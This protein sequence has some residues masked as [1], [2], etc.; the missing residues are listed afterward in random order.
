MPWHCCKHQEVHSACKNSDEVLVQWGKRLNMVLPLPSRDLPFWYRLT[1]SQSSHARTHTHTRLMALCLSLPGTRKVKPIWILLKQ[2][3]VSCSGISWAIWKSAPRSRQITTS[4]PHYSSFFY[5][6]DALPVAQPT[7]SKHWRQSRRYGNRK[8]Q[9]CLQKIINF[10]D[11]S[12]IHFFKFQKIFTWQAIQ[13][14]N[15]GE[16]CN[17]YKWACDEW[18]WAPTNT[19]QCAWD[20]SDP[21]Y[22]RTCLCTHTP[23]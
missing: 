19:H 13:Y 5:R 22:A 14:Q 23:I 2:E 6:P 3:T 17:V 12:G 15:T 18:R 20:Y 16:V 7:A 1:H 10:Q 4:A 9:W 11:I 21:V 8:T